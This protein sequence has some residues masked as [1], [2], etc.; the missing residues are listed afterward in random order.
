MK[1]KERKK[2]TR[3][4][5]ERKRKE[6]KGMKWEGEKNMKTKR[7]LQLGLLKHSKGPFKRFQHLLQQRS[8]QLLNQLPGRLD[9]SLNIVESIKKC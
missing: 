1:R 8:T 4:A 7:N 6:M 5:R 9:R 2:K 3:E